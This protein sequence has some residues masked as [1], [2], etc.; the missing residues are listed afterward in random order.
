MGLYIAGYGWQHEDWTGS[1]YPDDLPPE[2]RFDYYCN[3]YRA[4]LVPPGDWLNASDEELEQWLDDAP[5]GFRFFLEFS[6]TNNLGWP[7][8]LE[9]TE[10]LLPKLG[11]I[12]L[13]LAAGFDP[14]QVARELGKTGIGIPVCLGIERESAVPVMESIVTSCKKVGEETVCDGGE[15]AIVH[16]GSVSDH[17]QLRRQ[18]EILLPYAENGNAVLA[19]DDIDTLRAAKVI[20]ELMGIS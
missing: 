17:R 10:T 8:L 4:V 18:I 2:W 12:H 13:H 6:T 5:D 15:L 7:R 9:V 1:H 20:A 3:E 16:V 14:N 11:G 19:C